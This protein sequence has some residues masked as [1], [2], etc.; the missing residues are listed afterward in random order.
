MHVSLGLDGWEVVK[1]DNK[2]NDVHGALF[3][4]PMDY[5]RQGML[6]LKEFR[7]EDTT[8]HVYDRFIGAWVMFPHHDQVPLY[9]ARQ[10][11]A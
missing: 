4:I 11:Y 7:N 9:F 5:V 8:P 1:N 3:E 10:I 6:R 2:D